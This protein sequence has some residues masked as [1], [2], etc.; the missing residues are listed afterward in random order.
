MLILYDVKIFHA[1]IKLWKPESDHILCIFTKR[2]VCKET[3]Q[4]TQTL[5]HFTTHAATGY[6]HFRLLQPMNQ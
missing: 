4:P 6:S 2:K 3:I 1:Y 5:A